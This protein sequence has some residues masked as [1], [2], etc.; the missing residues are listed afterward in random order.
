[1]RGRRVQSKTTS[2]EWETSK[3]ISERDWSLL[4][5]LEEGDASSQFEGDE[6]A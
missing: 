3:K 2:Y 4:P 1:M 5:T 6:A